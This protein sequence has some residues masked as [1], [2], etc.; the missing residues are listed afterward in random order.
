ME[1]A[2]SV[3]ILH[4]KSVRISVLVG[5]TKDE[6]VMCFMRNILF[7]S[8]EEVLLVTINLVHLFIIFIPTDLTK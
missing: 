3:P 7:N 2:E 6:S 1:R 8:P 5:N 4:D